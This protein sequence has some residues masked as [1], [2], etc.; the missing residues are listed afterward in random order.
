MIA[1]IALSQLGNVGS[2][3]WYMPVAANQLFRD[4][5]LAVFLACVGLR[6]GNHFIQNVIGGGGITFVLWGAVVTLVPVFLVACVAR[7]V[8]KMNFV[9]LSG[10]V[11]GALT[12]TPAMLF[13]TEATGTDAPAVAYAAVAPLAMLAPV[14]C[15]QVLAIAMM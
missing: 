8:W 11:A 7:L 5:G 14:I 2:V 1:A 15:A 6:S 4:F 10:W 13:A 9:T 12:N 3:V